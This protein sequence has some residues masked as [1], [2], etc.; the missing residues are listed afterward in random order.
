[1]FMQGQ[2]NRLVCRLTDAKIRHGGF[3]DSFIPF[4]SQSTE[5]KTEGQ[6]VGK[7]LQTN[8]ANR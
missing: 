7:P 8:R 3:Y 6:R 2:L 5:S 1:M 4:K